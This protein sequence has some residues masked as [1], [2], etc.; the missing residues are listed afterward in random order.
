MMR[1]IEGSGAVVVEAVHDAA[2]SLVLVSQ[3]VAFRGAISCC[4]SMI[5]RIAIGKSLQTQHSSQ[6]CLQ[7][8]EDEGR[9]TVCVCVCGSTTITHGLR[10]DQKI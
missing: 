3:E 10:A 5:K 1:V 7:S 6:G 9:I 8:C 2:C 4:D